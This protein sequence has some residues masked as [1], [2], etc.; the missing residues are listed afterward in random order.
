MD[1]GKIGYQ[2][3]KPCLRCVAIKKEQFGANELKRATPPF[4]V[5]QNSIRVRLA[6]HKAAGGDRRR[7]KKQVRRMQMWGFLMC[8]TLDW[9]W[10]FKQ[11]IWDDVV[12]Y[13]W[14]QWGHYQKDHSSWKYVKKKKKKIRLW[15]GKP[16]KQIDSAI[17]DLTVYYSV[18]LG[19]IGIKL[20]K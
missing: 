13:I 7:G 2:S 18:C 1:L 20:R 6:K 10:D 9:C 17:F 3:T 11:W 8:G 16:L 14:I 12:F 4:V 15:I 19:Y 5:P